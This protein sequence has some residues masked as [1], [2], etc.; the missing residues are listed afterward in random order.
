MMSTA[1][2]DFES[3]L[4]S[5]EEI[6]PTERIPFYREVLGRMMLKM[7]PK[8]AGEQFLAMRPFIGFPI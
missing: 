6:E 3:C 2:S 1:A 5:T 7:E 4:F 8:P